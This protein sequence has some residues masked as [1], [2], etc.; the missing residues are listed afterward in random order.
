L[1]IENGL[2]D[3]ISWFENDELSDPYYDLDNPYNTLM[4]DTNGE[5]NNGIGQSGESP[6]LSTKNPQTHLDEITEDEAVS[7]YSS[8]QDRKRTIRETAYNDQTTVEPLADEPGLE[9][10]SKY[11]DIDL[12]SIIFEDEIDET[13]NNQKRLSIIIPSTDDR[14]RD[15]RQIS[16]IYGILQSHP[17]HDQFSFQLP[18]IQK[19]TELIIFPNDGINISQGLI[20]KLR[21]LLGEENVTV[22]DPLRP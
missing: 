1:N 14:D 9:N 11:D 12:D 7:V 21:K 8:D 20:N 18:G 13:P 15:L 16:H 3:N 10:T 17:G 4:Y 22:E 5:I 2:D 6:D 19:A